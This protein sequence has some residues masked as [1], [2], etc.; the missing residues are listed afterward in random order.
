[1]P[2]KG[3]GKKSAREDDDDDDDDGATAGTRT[4][5]TMTTT[6]T[7]MR[8]DE[9]EGE[10]AG[11]IVH[12]SSC[13]PRRCCLCPIGMSTRRS[14]SRSR[15]PERQPLLSPAPEFRSKKAKKAAKARA[16]DAV[17]EEEQ[18]DVTPPPPSVSLGGRA[19]PPL[20]LG[21]ARAEMDEADREVQRLT[22]CDSVLPDFHLPAQLP[23][24]PRSCSRCVAAIMSSIASQSSRLEP[25]GADN[26]HS[27]KNA[28][29]ASLRAQGLWAYVQ[30]RVRPE[31]AE[32]DASA[33]TRRRTR[34]E[35]QVWEDKRSQAAGFIYSSIELTRQSVITDAIKDNA[36]ACWAAVAAQ[37]GRLSVHQM[38][39]IRSRVNDVK[40]VDGAS[41]T[42]H[43]A[44]FYETQRQLV[45]TIMEINDGTLAWMLL[46]SV[47]ESFES[48]VTGLYSSGGYGTDGQFTF[49][50]I[51]SAF[52]ME[53]QRRRT[54]AAETTRTQQAAVALYH[55]G[56]QGGSRMSASAPLQSSPP[57]A[58]Q[59]TSRQRATC[60]HCGGTGH[61]HTKCYILHPEQAPT[62]WRPPAARAR[63]VADT[64]N[65]Q[66]A[67]LISSDSSEIALVHTQSV[68]PDDDGGI[69][70]DHA[71]SSCA[72][73]LISVSSPTASSSPV[74][75]VDSAASA[76]YCPHLSWFSTYEQQPA[77][78]FVTTGGNHRFP[79][80]GIGNIELL[81]HSG[82]GTTLVTLHRVQHAPGLTHNLLS[83]PSM[84]SM[85]ATVSFSGDQCVISLPGGR[86]L[87]TA[88][89]VGG[90]QL[91]SVR[92]SPT[93]LRAR[94]QAEGTALV[95]STQ[96]S[97]A[98]CLRRWHMRFGHVNNAAIVQLFERELVKG[99]DCSVEAASIRRAV[100]LPSAHCESC[101]VAKSRRQPFPPTTTSRASRPLELLHTD[102][103]GPLRV[104]HGAV[105]A[106][107]NAGLTAAAPAQPP[108]DARPTD[109]ST[110]PAAP[111]WRRSSLPAA[112]AN[113][114]D[115]DTVMLPVTAAAVAAAAHSA[116]ALPAVL[117]AA[118]AAASDAAT[119]AAA[120]HDAVPD[121][122]SA[123][124]TDAVS[125]TADAELCSG[126]PDLRAASAAQLESA[127][128]RL[129]ADGEDA[130]VRAMRR[131]RWRGGRRAAAERS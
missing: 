72:S 76:H 30:G 19:T 45:G 53:E 103:C 95:S 55:R 6:M 48:L 57:A 100:A 9:G 60:T 50:R 123:M 85:G 102:I 8:L 122:A 130:D 5:T 2:K 117:D 79:V 121:D 83:V 125:V 13:C 31:D 1:M 11:S 69:A 106:T 4:T 114:G 73:P 65:P 78:R 113:D 88:D 84:D 32:A 56:Q 21:L 89:R 126:Q 90:G 82:A 109:S 36:R 71:A 58:T 68:L 46:T 81:L 29:E 127:G 97:Q 27:W 104:Q 10:R 110:L 105:S 119:A 54:A 75:L 62:G 17:P 91:Y 22:A 44:L 66:H 28:M 98:D 37:Y 39:R 51:R 33:E 43:I 70:L 101:A 14:A 47:P 16:S 20:D 52:L 96:S 86:L 64:A 108:D 61:L 26:W 77:G 67:A 107:R 112:A 7:T 25:L 15:S 42:D 128:A 124:M 120:V 23:L 94:A 129:E 63:F 38:G 111:A 18:E 40:Y 49:E 92:A 115:G 116:R 80:M 24:F 12:C 59:E 3:K 87:V 34:V 131:S 74:W 99:V 118:A 35:Q 93:A 41:M